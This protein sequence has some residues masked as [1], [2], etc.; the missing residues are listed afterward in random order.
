[1]HP[2]SR[3][4]SHWAQVLNWIR[5][6]NQ[7]STNNMIK[8]LL[9]CRLSHKLLHPWTVSQLDPSFL[10]LFWSG[11]FI[12]ASRKV[13]R[14]L[15]HYEQCQ[16]KLLLD[17]ISPQSERLLLRKQRKKMTSVDKDAEQEELWLNTGGSGNWS[18]L[19]TKV[20][21]QVS[22]KIKYRTTVWPSHT[23]PEPISKGLYI[24][25]LRYC[26][27]MLAAALFTRARRWN[28]CKDAPADEWLI[29]CYAY[30][31]MEFCLT[32][33]EIKL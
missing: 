22:Q 5:R 15:S 7:L 2:K 1:M 18:L 30:R 8:L 25:P 21:V 16:L 33:R 13:S 17:S 19:A 29:K 27:S 12:T 20:S 31:V 4:P 32:T 14:T 3:Q 9:L 26:I 23:V 28:Q 11:C 10:E 24:L 6:R